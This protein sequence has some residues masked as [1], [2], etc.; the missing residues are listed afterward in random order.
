ME[1]LANELLTTME[2]QISQALGVVHALETQIDGKPALVDTWPTYQGGIPESFKPSPLEFFLEDVEG[3]EAAIEDLADEATQLAVDNGYQPSNSID[4][5]RY[6]VNMGGFAADE[7]H[8]VLPILWSK[9]ESP[10]WVPGAN[11]QIVV[12]C[13]DELIEDRVSSWMH[14]PASPMSRHFSQGLRE[15]LNSTDSHGRPIGDHT[16]RLN[17]FRQKLLEAKNQSAPLVELNDGLNAVVHRSHPMI[18]EKPLLQGFPFTIGHPAREIVTGVM[19]EGS[20]F[21]DND[22][23][24]VLISSFIEYPFH[25]MIVNSFVQPLGTVL[26]QI[27]ENKGALQGG[28]WRFRRTKTLEDFI[29]L[30]DHTRLAMI[31]GFAVARMLG[32]ATADPTREVSITGT[33]GPL[34]FPFPLLT[35]VSQDN[36]L[37]ALMEAFVKCYGTVQV[38]HG[39]AFAPYERLYQLGEGS[40]K[41]YMLHGEAETFLRDGTIAFAAED[42][43]RYERA[44][45]ETEEERTAN[46]VT[47]LEENIKRFKTIKALP[48][49]GQE[50]RNSDGTVTPEDAMT[51]ELVDDLIHGYGEVLTSLKT[52]STGSVV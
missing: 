37:P 13:T 16:Q 38:E 49:S 44:C 18:D 5:T 26:N 36:I 11:P 4:A 21:S 20:H 14:R 30:P 25:P 40:G 51:I 47:Y 10:Q 1:A 24:S 45:A 6:L 39:A 33:D 3:W 7:Q 35:E 46:L 15:Y 34:R 28:F 19:G 22:R 43:S 29:P 23:E 12:A 9:S 50:I 32:Y 8:D 31:R 2:A 52:R 27:G 41:V 17:L 42:Q 48:F